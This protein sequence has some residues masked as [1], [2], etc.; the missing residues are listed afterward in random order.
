MPDN[1][2]S[3]AESKT[4]ETALIE[5]AGFL[6][7][8]AGTLAERWARL[9]LDN[10]GRGAFFSEKRV[11]KTFRELVENFIGCLKEGRVDAYLETLSEKGE[12]F[13]RLGIPFEEV[14]IS[15]HLF[16]EV[17]ASEFLETYPHRSKLPE[18]LVDL[19][20]IHNEGLT[21]LAISYFRAAKKEMQK[22]TGGL[23]EE[24]LSLR[25]E[26]SKTKDFAFLH[27]SK[28]LS[29][30]QLVINNINHKL[31]NRLHQ[32][33]R[34]QKLAEAIDNEPHLPKLLKIVTQHL[35]L[36][37]PAYSN[38]YFGLFD[39]ERKR[40]TVYHQESQ[41]SPE[42]S[43][44][45]TFYAS[46]LP[47]EFQDALYDESK[48]FE[49][50]K[51]YRSLPKSLIDAVSPHIQREFL[52]L[53]IRKFHEVAGFMLIGTPLEHFFGKTNYKFYQRLGQTISKALVSAILFTKTKKQDEFTLLL[54]ELKKKGASAEPLNTVLD[55]CL[56]SLINILGAER[57]SVM[58]YD[59]SARELKVCAAKGYKVYPIS[60]IPV[61]WGEGIAGLALK[62]AKII[63]I[64]KLKETNRMNLLSRF[65]R[66]EEAPEIRLKSLLCIPLLE[67]EKPLGVVN[68]STINFYKDFDASEIE[69]AN[70]V[71]RSM[72]ALVKELSSC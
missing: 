72:T 56:G 14:M 48:K 55:F 45:E 49:H 46:E 40:V 71:V 51:G 60:G 47:K 54:D 3:T 4:L 12:T 50:F 19:E 8:L 39:E 21:A 7:P 10:F 22:I 59:D 61:K 1:L 43:F 13:Y 28:E 23:Q 63:S 33:S 42:C 58:R 70:H 18:I 24:N 62:E 2:V 38:V 36:N 15:L 65:M 26:L 16:E 37:C 6:S 20:E 29:S 9:Y 53:P 66:H 27:T 17:C 68:I 44:L 34:I 57:S 32:L 30:M 35:L 67:E 25:E 5:Q 41:P 69:M 64:S 52:V 31:K 11:G